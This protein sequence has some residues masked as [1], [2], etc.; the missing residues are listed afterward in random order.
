MESSFGNLG[1]SIGAWHLRRVSSFGMREDVSAF[2]V[3]RFEVGYAWL[4]MGA[5]LASS[6]LVSARCPRAI[7]L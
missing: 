6:E 2:C 7:T 1:A 5:V 4:I 3:S